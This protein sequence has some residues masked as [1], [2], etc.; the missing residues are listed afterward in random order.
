QEYWP[1][2]AASYDDEYK[3]RVLGLVQERLKYFAELPS[4]T[5][6]FFEDLP[7]DME[8]VDGNK[9]LKKVDHAELKQLLEQAKA[10][11][12]QSDFS[13]DDLTER[14][15]RLL[16]STGQKPGVLFSLIRVATTSAPASPGLAD[17]L[18]V[19]G[20]DRSLQRID[21]WLTAL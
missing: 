17:T 19:L 3:R 9:Q 1:A 5:V 14:L 11:L 20:K 12:A 8:L 21:S 7:V 18:A 16:E 6:F 15:N 13:T 10:S 4:L 2:S